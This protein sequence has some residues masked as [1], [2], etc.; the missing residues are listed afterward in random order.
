MVGTVEENK[1]VGN[2]L[3]GAVPFLY[4]YQTLCLYDGDDDGV[5]VLKMVTSHHRDL[6]VDPETT[7]QNK[8]L[9]P[10]GEVR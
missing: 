1:E 2:R 3:N 10:S 6:L 7:K 4:Y 5:M 8:F 9:L